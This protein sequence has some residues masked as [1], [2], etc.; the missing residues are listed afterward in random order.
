[1]E[2]ELMNLLRW[3]SFHFIHCKE[4]E[5]LTFGLIVAIFSKSWTCVTLKLEIP[6]Y[7]AA[8]LVATLPAGTNFSIAFHVAVIS[9]S[10]FP[11]AVPIGK[12]IMAISR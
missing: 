2:F 9:Y 4:V 11:F 5:V 1:M 3:V 6:M 8:P 7:R 12:C 10:G